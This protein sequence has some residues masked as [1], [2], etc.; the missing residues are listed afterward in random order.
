MKY[1]GDPI[2]IYPKPYSIY[3]RGTIGS[4]KDHQGWTC[5]LLRDFRIVFPNKDPLSI[6]FFANLFCSPY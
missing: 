5:G 1:Y 3:L 6:V 2:I 4:P